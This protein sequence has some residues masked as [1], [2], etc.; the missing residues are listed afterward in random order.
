VTQ[1]YHTSNGDPI[2]KYKTMH[3]NTIDVT[4]GIIPGHSKFSD[5]NFLKQ[6]DKQPNVASDKY[7]NET[8]NNIGLF[9]CACTHNIIRSNKLIKVDIIC[10]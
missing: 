9:V 10:D 5:L 2:I 6:T 7:M 4:N 8:I 3:D 1:K